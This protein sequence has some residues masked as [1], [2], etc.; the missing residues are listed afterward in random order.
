MTGTRTLPTFD[1]RLEQ[2]G[3]PALH[4]DGLEVLQVNLG[5]MCNQTC[6]HCHVDAGPDRKERM[7]RE[8]MEQCLEAVK[9][10]SIKTVDLTGGAPEMHPDFRWLVERCTELGVHV[11]VRCNLTIILANK[12]Y[13][14]LPEFYRDHKV[15]VV[16][17]LPF[18][19][20]DRTDRQRGEGVFERS[21]R[22]LQMLNKVGYGMPG[23]GLILDL[24]YNPSGTLLPGSQGELEKQFKR[25]L[26]ADH[27][28]SFDRLFA[29]T[30]LPISRFLE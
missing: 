13:N 6:T 20:A 8:V 26:S 3:L 1:A 16:S 22:A 25:S 28:I 21:I 17:S 30:N 23:S 2:A 24:V 7:S 10:H 12:K 11:M 14:D 5:R 4:A 29:I 27:G 9:K 15:E 19:T 18:Y